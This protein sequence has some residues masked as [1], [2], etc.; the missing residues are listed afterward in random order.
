[1]GHPSIILA[2]VPVPVD[3]RLRIMILAVDGWPTMATGQSCVESQPEFTNETNCCK[4]IK[5]E[6]YK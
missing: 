5:H 6:K 4:Y 1:M 2:L 3:Q